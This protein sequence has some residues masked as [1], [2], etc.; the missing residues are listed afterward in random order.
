MDWVIPDIANVTL[1]N[2]EI[3]LF[4]FNKSKK[5]ILLAFLVI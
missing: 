2:D 3:L 1:L 5:S 4:S